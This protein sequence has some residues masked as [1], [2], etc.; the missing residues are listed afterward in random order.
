MIALPS[1]RSVNRRCRHIVHSRTVNTSQPSK[2]CC[3][4]DHLPVSKTCMCT[5]GFPLPSPAPYRASKS[6][7]PSFVISHSIPPNPG[8]KPRGLVTPLSPTSKSPKISSPSARWSSR[9]TTSP[10]R[11]P[12]H[13]LP[14]VPRARGPRRW[15][16]R[17][18]RHHVRRCDDPTLVLGLHLDPAWCSHLLESGVEQPPRWEDVQQLWVVQCLMTSVRRSARPWRYDELRE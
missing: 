8:D 10:W 1:C 12:S 11:P 2:T 13:R 14:A 4:G 5:I 3:I 18:H 9:S 6:R 17:I 16:G 15:R 7:Y